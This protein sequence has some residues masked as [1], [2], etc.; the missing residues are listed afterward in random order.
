MKF[1]I[2]VVDRSL[3]SKCEFYK[4]GSVRFIFYL[5]ECMNLCLSFLHVLTDLGEIR[6]S[7]SSHIAIALFWVL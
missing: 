7:I 6:Y 4:I 2:T 5:W 3:Y 1:G